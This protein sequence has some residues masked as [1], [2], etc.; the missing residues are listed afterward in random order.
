MSNFKIGD[1]VRRLYYEA[2]GTDNFPETGAVCTVAEVDSRGDVHLQGRSG[3]FS[4][5]FFELVEP[6]VSERVAELESELVR[7]RADH[8]AADNDFT[9]AIK[10]RDEARAELN[11]LKRSKSPFDPDQAFQIAK[12]IEKV[13]RGDTELAAG[14]RSVSIAVPPRSVFQAMGIGTEDLYG[15]GLQTVTVSW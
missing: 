15:P 11:A 9:E 10:Q 7:V 14:R 2:N 5:R 1:K 4:A 8:Q 6:S 12:A 13:L 3:S